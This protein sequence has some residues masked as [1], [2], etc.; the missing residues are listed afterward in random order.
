MIFGR[1][2]ERELDD[3]IRAHLRLAQ[4]DRIRQGESPED[5]AVSARRE[6]GNVTRVKENTRDVWGW[7]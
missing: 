5:A 7:R 6:F 1:R 4:Q 3:E 2:R